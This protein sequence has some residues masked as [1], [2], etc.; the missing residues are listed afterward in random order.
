MRDLHTIS[1]CGA[2]ALL[3]C[4]GLLLTLS[5]CESPLKPTSTEELRAQMRA[6]HQAYLEA[7]AAGG[8][9]EISRDPSDVEEQLTEERIEELDAQSGPTAYDEAELDLGPDLMGELDGPKVSLSLEEAIRLSVAN[10]LTVQ[11]AKLNPKIAEAQIGQAEAIFEALFFT[12]VS[13]GKTDTPRPLLTTPP[14]PSGDQKIDSFEMTTGIRKTFEPGTVVEVFMDNNR[15]A[16]NPTLLSIPSYYSTSVGVTV[17]QPIL[18]GFGSDINTAEIQLAESAQKAQVEAL[19]QTLLQTVSQVET[20]Y[21]NLVVAHQLVMIQKRLLERTRFDAERLKKREGFDVSPVEITEAYSLVELRRADFIRARANIRQASDQLKTLIRSPE[22]TVAGEELI[23]PSDVAAED[24]IEYSLLDA[25]STALQNRPEINQSLESINSAEIQ[26][27][28]AENLKLPELNLGG[29]I[30]YN[31][32]GDDVG[33]SYDQLTDADYIDYLLSAQLEV[34][35]GNLEAE[36][37]FEQRQLER[38]Q[39]M[40]DY[41]DVAQTVVLE[42]KNAMRELRASYELI[43]ATRAARRAAADQLR[44]IAEQEKAGVALTPEFLL[45]RKL[46]TQQRLADAETQEIQALT[47]YQTAIADLFLATGTL[48]EKNG[49]SFEEQLNEGEEE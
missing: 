23:V 41:Q 20:A 39:S 17:T 36:S 18:R 49:I 44:A 28:V 24:A 16:E 34:P 12:D 45:N 13:W 32:A 10:N 29:T 1:G 42:V 21:W 11:F 2:V 48:L 9:I 27:R 38:Q 33:D 15:L 4:S 3:A 43:G 26:L 47:G 8:V 37:L 19:R 14:P 35:L 6:S 30:R 40:V 22:F 31:G 7:V 46:P 5:G 25:V